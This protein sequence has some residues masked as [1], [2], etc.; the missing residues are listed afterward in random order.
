MRGSDGGWYI[1]IPRLPQHPLHIGVKIAYCTPKSFI[2][3]WIL[4]HL[5]FGLLSNFWLFLKTVTVSD[6]LCIFPLCSGPLVCNPAGLCSI[7]TKGA[8]CRAGLELA[9]QRTALWHISQSEC[10]WHQWPHHKRT[11]GPRTTEMLRKQ[12]KGKWCYYWG[13]TLQFS[14]Q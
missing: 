11:S 2:F 1:A 13:S 7:N 14:V 12:R 4:S 5:S 8:G 9:N 10:M 3:K 6:P